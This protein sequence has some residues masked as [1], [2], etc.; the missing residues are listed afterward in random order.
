MKRLLLFAA[1]FALIACLGCDQSKNPASPKDAALVGDEIAP[2]RAD[3]DDAELSAQE[4]NGP[5]NQSAA[6]TIKVPDDY[7][8]IQAAVDAANAGDKIVV[9]ASGSPYNE[10]V[11]IRKADLQITAKGSVTVNGSFLVQANGVKIDYFHVNVL[12][13]PGGPDGGID[14]GAVSGVKIRHNTI[15]GNNRGIF[16]NGSTDCLIEKNTC[17]GL[18]ADG[19]LLYYNANGNTITKNTCTGNIEGINLVFS[20][21][22]EVSFNDCS[23]NRQSG[24]ALNG[25]NNKFK[26]N[27][28]NRNGTGIT[29]NPGAGSN[30]FG[31]GNTANFNVSYGI[32][33]ALANNNTV[34]KNNLHCNTVGDVLDFGTGNTFINNSTGPL[35][36]GCQ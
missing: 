32:I 3:A 29:A 17:T 35:P 11:F 24:I 23:T 28:C 33:L 15:T 8:T 10:N 13:P 22:N 7:P 27:V 34:K 9:K 26:N 2:Q 5:E 12:L 21:N 4:Q 18:P 16:L 14:I 36:G 25:S 20:N 31:P 19:I 30:S 1:A 6:A